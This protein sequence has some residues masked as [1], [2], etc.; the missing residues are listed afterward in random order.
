MEV[1]ADMV[2]NI[3]IEIYKSEGV[4]ESTVLLFLIKFSGFIEIN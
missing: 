1:K 4:F 2:K 3:M